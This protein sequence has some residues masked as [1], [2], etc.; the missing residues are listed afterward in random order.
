MSDTIRNLRET[1][2]QKYIT[3]AFS[4]VAVVPAPP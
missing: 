1:L 4:P 3:P 2:L